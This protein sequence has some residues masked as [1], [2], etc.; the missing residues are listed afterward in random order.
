LGDARNQ[1][2][3]VKEKMRVLKESKRLAEL[4]VIIRTP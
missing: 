1:I 4:V 3:I 2:D